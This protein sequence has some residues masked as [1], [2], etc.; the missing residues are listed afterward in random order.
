MSKHFRG[1]IWTNI[2]ENVLEAINK[3]NLEPVTGCVGGDEYS[4]WA[5]D[6]VQSFFKDEIYATFAINGTGANIVAMKVMLPRYASIVCGEE[7][8]INVYEAGA[9][10]YN[11]GNKI[12]EVETENGKLVVDSIKKKLGNLKKYKY[13]PKVIIL[14]QPTELGALYT[15]DELKAICDYAH[16]NGMY[17]YIDGA[18]IGNALVSLNTN[19]TDMIEYADV[20]AF[21]LGGT[22]MGAM[23]GEMI[24]FRRKEFSENLAYI[25]KQTCQH[26]DR[27]KFMGVQFKCLLEDGLWL[28][29]AK[30]GNENAKTLEKMFLEKGIKAYY[31]VEANMVFV[32]I[33]DEQL[34][35]ITKVY[36]VHYWNEEL[37]IV[38]F[39]ATAKSDISEMKKLMELI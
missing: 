17:V 16:E 24:I 37:K 6:Y 19:L 34:D 15:N 32:P 13:L 20:D 14:T 21:S 28:R 39:S 30:K 36:D 10:E 18:R 11:L 2:D 29:N 25:Q 27:S 12:I 35:R 8:H 3:A 4:K 26:F 1:E 9:F 22:K 7:T 31:P 33:T 38:R 5:I 23:F